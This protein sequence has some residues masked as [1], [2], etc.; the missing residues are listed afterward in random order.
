MDTVH[1]GGRDGEKNIYHTNTVDAVTQWEILGCVGRIHR[2]EFATKNGHIL[3]RTELTREQEQI[4][5]RLGIGPPPE[6]EKA[7]LVSP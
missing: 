2:V 3:Q 6:V 1:Q 7:E 5:K 4:P